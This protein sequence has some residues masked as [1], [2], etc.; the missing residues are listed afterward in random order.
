MSSIINEI[1]NTFIASNDAGIPIIVRIMHDPNNPNKAVK[2]HP[3][4]HSTFEVPNGTRKVYYFLCVG[5]HEA[6]D[7]LATF[8]GNRNVF[9][10]WK[11]YKKWFADFFAD[12]NQEV[13]N[14]LEY[15]GIF[16][17]I[18]LFFDVR[19]NACA[20][21]MRFDEGAELVFACQWDYGWNMALIPAEA[22]HSKDAVDYIIQEWETG[23]GSEPL[24]PPLEP[25]PY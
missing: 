25:I 5:W 15:N 9:D 2:N 1:K 17:D 18:D 8:Q 14:R 7:V 24:Q 11:G 3:A 13:R 20:M 10:H 23:I 21:D 4:Y 16:P 22:A 19:G 12:N 6:F